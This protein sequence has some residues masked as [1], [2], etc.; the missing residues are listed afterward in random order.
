MLAYGYQAMLAAQAVERLAIEEEIFAELLVPSQ[1]SPVDWAPVERSVRATG[2]LVTIEEGTGGWSWGSEAAA[3]ISRSLFGQ[4]RH[5]VDVVA[6]GRDII[7]SSKL[8]ESAV[9]V[10]ANRIDAAI[11]AAAA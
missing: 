8:K 2:Y 1:I 10:G 11:R 4:L 6:S 3:V 9:L 7:P 5:P